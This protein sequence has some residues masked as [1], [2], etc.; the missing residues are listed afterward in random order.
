M[1]KRGSIVENMRVSK[2]SK[3]VPREVSRTSSEDFAS[4]SV[5]LPVE[6]LELLRMAAVKRASRQGGR[7]NV[8]EIVREA[9]EEYRGK[10]EAEL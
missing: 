1:A 4:T 5:H 7:P 2:P 3:A 10:I 9:L 8:S 6:L